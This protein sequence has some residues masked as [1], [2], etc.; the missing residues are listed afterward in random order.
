MFR[1]CCLAVSE[2][3]FD[4]VLNIKKKKKKDFPEIKASFASTKA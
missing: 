1:S 2:N 4:Y 3:T